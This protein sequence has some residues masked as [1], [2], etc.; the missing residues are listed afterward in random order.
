MIKSTQL[1]KTAQKEM[2]HIDKLLSQGDSSKKYELSGRINIVNSTL[3]DCF[4]EFLKEKEKVKVL[5]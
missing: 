3:N 1:F 2:K 4:K 5:V